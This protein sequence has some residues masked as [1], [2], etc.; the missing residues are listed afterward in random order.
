MF[1]ITFLDLFSGIG[2]FRLGLERAG[3]ECVGHC[4]IDKYA[5][6][7]YNAIHEPKEGEWYGEDITKVSAKELPRADI[8]CFGFPCQDISIAG[9]QKGVRIGTRSGLF[10][11][12]TALL[13]EIEESHRPSILFIENVK[14][15]L[16]INGGWVSRYSLKWTV[17]TMQN[18]KFSIQRFR[19]PKTEK[20][21]HYRTSRGRMDEVFPITKQWT[22]YCANWEYKGR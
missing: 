8:W 12:V 19:V 22:N 11:S 14:N 6:A 4:E 9:K 1:Y 10:Y 2:G 3:H 17:G 13:R 16:S 20:G 15:L 5:N 18:G 21:L 7:S